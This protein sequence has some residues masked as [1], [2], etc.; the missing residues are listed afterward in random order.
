[1]SSFP[2]GEAIRTDSTMVSA[3]PN[4]APFNDISKGEVIL[5]LA[6]ARLMSSWF[7]LHRFIQPSDGSGRIPVHP[8][9]H[10]S[11]V[12]MRH[13]R[14]HCGPVRT[15]TQDGRLPSPPGGSVREVRRVQRCPAAL[16]SCRS[17][18]SVP[19]G[20][21]RS[22]ACRLLHA[23]QT[24]SH[25]LRRWP[26]GGGRW[27]E[28]PRGLQGA[29]GMTDAISGAR[30]CTPLGPSPPP[31]CRHR[32]SGRRRASPIAVPR[33]WPRRSIASPTHRD[34]YFP[35]AA[36]RLLSRRRGGGGWI[37]P[38]RWRAAPV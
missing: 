16:A 26:V 1:M 29:P 34:R 31:A 13:V 30:P 23:L 38:V 10:G 33:H 35:R 25:R 36:I 17:P 7:V 22:A 3:G 28:H 24:R 14:D 27:R 15:V 9:R 18:A 37:C 11:S 2:G 8:I 32:P 21:A 6:A 4:A 19:G 12:E 5:V 20:C